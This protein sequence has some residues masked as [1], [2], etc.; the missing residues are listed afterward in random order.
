MRRLGWLLFGATCACAVVQAVLLLSADIPLWSY[1]IVVDEGFPLVPIGSVLGA[2]VGAI[3]ISRY[4]RNLIGWLFAAGQLGNEIGG[5]ISAIIIRLVAQGRQAAIP[6]SLIVGGQL[7]SAIWTMTFLALIYLLAPDGRVPSRR[8]RYT[9]LIPVGAL[10]LQYGVVLAVPPRVLLRGESVEIGW[11]T[12]VAA[13][14]SYLIVAVAVGIGAAAIWRRLL[15][16]TGESRQQLLWLAA[17]GAALTATSVIALVSQLLLVNP[18]WL[19]IVPWHLSYIFVSI[20]VGIAILRYRLFDIDVILSRTIVLATLGAFVTVGYVAVV[21]TIGWALLYGFGTQGEDLYWPSLVATGLVAAGFQPLRRRVLRWT[22]R[23]VYGERAAPYE[24][25]ADLNRELADRPT[26]DAMPTLVAETAGRAVG[27]VRAVATVGPAHDPLISAVWERPGAARSAA[28]PT[29]HATTVEDLGEPVGCVSV[30]LPAGRDLRPFEQ[31][32][33]ADIGRQAGVAFRGALLEAQVADHIRQIEAS[34]AELARS[35]RRLVRAEDEARERFAAD[36]DHRVLPLLAAA[37]DD[38]ADTSGAVELSDRLSGAIGRVESA[39]DELRSVV[40]GVFPALLERRGLVPALVA[41]LGRLPDV[42]LELGGLPD[43]RLDRDVEAAA[44][45]FCVE[46]TPRDRPG[47]VRLRV[48][49]AEL[50]A[51]VE[52]LDGSVA[53]PERWLHVRDRLAALDGSMTV[54]A[55]QGRDVARAVVPL[56]GQPAVARPSDHSASSRSGPNDDFGR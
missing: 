55:E 3:I 22:D 52:G 34:S 39:L 4:P 29:E 15:S 16:A 7:F 38:L 24:A 35:R 18:P 8:W 25:L 30:D 45:L 33:L 10:L 12:A 5:M 19:L 48:R 47:T 26:P 49:H 31:A 27:A 28:R 11:E 50:T 13:V 17:S 2:A 46:V 56:A 6:D 44:Y 23:L 37:R 40:R 41:E 20:S 32:L 9:P 51:Q 21:V 54:A 53:S 1:E 36:I 14:L 42:A 43:E